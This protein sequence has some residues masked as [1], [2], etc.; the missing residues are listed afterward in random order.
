MILDFPKL[1]SV[2]K[3]SLVFYFWFFDHIIFTYKLLNYVKLLSNFFR[4]DTKR[5]LL[6][7]IIS[8]AKYILFPFSFCK[9]ILKLHSV[10]K[11][12]I[13]NY[14]NI[15]YLKNLEILTIIISH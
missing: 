8:L 3:I 4:F 7:S 11:K 13:F 6:I 5:K 10:K 1:T 14:Q 9:I 2:F 12:I 15:V